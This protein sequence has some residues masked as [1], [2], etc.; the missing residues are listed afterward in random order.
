VPDERERPQ[1]KRR[2]EDANPVGHR[3][4]A[5]SGQSPVNHP[6]EREPDATAQYRVKDSEENRGD[7][8]DGSSGRQSGSKKRK[9]S[10]CR[11]SRQKRQ[12]DDNAAI[13]DAEYEVDEILEVRIHHGRRQYRAKWSGY[14]DDP[15][16]YPEG[17]FE[18][19]PLK[20]LEFHEANPSSRGRPKRLKRWIKRFQREEDAGDHLD[21]VQAQVLGRAENTQESPSHA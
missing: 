18:Y 6:S 1:L 20:L 11:S 21:V 16:W 9:K 19:S 15:I 5:P 10:A 12:R 2:R 8:S 17:N 13:K 7:S 14:E 3:E 4:L